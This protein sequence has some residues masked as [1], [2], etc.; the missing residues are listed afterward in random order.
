MS[1]KISLVPIFIC[2][3][4]ALQAAAQD[5]SIKSY[6]FLGTGCPAG[7]TTVATDAKNQA[8]LARFNAFTANVGPGVPIS[9]SR[10]N[11]D[12]TL[13]IS[14][15]DGYKF[16]FNHFGYYTGYSLDKSVNARYN[17][18]Y[19]FQSDIAEGGGNGNVTGLSSDLKYISTPVSPPVWSDCGIDA[20]V[21]VDTAVRVSNTANRSGS[22][23]FNYQQLNILPDSF[24][25]ARC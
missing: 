17:T 19:Y 7:S 9:H 8:L 23:T 24:T 6:A 16:S 15:P 21:I 5:Y 20:T 18:Y 13:T 11:C 2:G 3:F 4:L 14:V 1:V 10:K 25:W 22:G 12:A